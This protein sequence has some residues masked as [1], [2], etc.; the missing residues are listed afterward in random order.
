MNKQFLKDSVGWGIGLWLIGYVLGIILFMAGTANLIGWII[1]LVGILITFWVLFLKIKGNDM[2]YYFKIAIAWTI[3][4]I[5][6][7]YIFLVKLFNPADGYY[8]LDIYF[9]YFMTFALPL[10]VG[11][12][13]TDKRRM[14]FGI[15]EKQ[16]KEKAEHKQK[17][18]SFLAAQDEVNPQITNN[19]VEKLLGV[20]NATA[21]RYLDE[22]EQEGALKQVGKTG[23]NVYYKKA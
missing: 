15:L 21:E 17:I 16:A 7:D 1:S 19:D 2:F 3:I 6:F 4:A 23:R 20:S 14:F 8:K 22:L 13:K 9:Y 5:A 18:L 11:I 10:L 12:F